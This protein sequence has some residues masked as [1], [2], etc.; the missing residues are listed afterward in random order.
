M[1]NV[2]GLMEDAKNELRAI[3]GWSKK[4][5]MPAKY[6]KRFVQEQASKTV[7]EVYRNNCWSEIET[8]L[9]KDVWDAAFS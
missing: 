1:V 2:T 5:V 6:A 7:M 8:D 3:G 4:S 9:D